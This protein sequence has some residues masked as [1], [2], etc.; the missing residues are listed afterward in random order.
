MSESCSDNCQTCGKTC[1]ERREPQSMQAAPNPKSNIK[2]VIGGGE[3]Q[4]W[5]G[6]IARYLADR[7]GACEAGKERGHP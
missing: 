7:C 6:Q 5:C 1:A 2:N 4:G 3:R